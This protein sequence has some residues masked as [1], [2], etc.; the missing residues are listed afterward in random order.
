M[1]YPSLLPHPPP[2]FLSFLLPLIPPSSLLW[3]Q[4]GQPDPL[5]DQS[6]PLVPV[7]PVLQTDGMMK[8]IRE[9]LMLG[10]NGDGSVLFRTNS[11]C[12]NPVPILQRTGSAC[13]NGTAEQRGIQSSPRSG[14]DKVNGSTNGQRA[15]GRS[16]SS[17][18]ANCMVKRSAS[19]SSAH[20]LHR[21][22]STT[23]SSIRSRSLEKLHRSCSGSGNEGRNR[24]SRLAPKSPTGQPSLHSE[25]G[26]P[27]TGESHTLQR[28]Q[29]REQNGRSL[30]AQALEVSG[31]AAAWGEKEAG[32][33]GAEES[34]R[35][36]LEGKRI[37]VSH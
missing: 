2:P 26:P 23:T 16:S 18:S 32:E 28:L 33:A 13:R 21:S 29:Q 8:R 17:S 31:A 1:P 14:G 20:V 11:S 37:L 27:G 5:T 22:S 9:S 24:R 4:A 12:Q 19:T 25:I 15:M 6:S 3:Q 10:S 30:V 34:V 35:R 36:M 7:Q